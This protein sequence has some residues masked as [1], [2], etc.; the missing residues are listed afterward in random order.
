M[1]DW[2]AKSRNGCD[3]MKRILTKSIECT[4]NHNKQIQILSRTDKK[5]I[6]NKFGQSG[7]VRDRPRDHLTK[8][9]Y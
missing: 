7:I 5:E 1:S 4:S 6:I 2:T 8:I 3:H 9:L